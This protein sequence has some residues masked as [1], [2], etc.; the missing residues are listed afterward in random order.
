MAS[1]ARVGFLGVLLVGGLALP[2]S[3]VAQPCGAWSYGNPTPNGNAVATGGGTVVVVAAGG[4]L[5]S[6]DGGPWRWAA[7][8]EF[9]QWTRVAWGSGRFAAIAS[10][11]ILVSEDGLAWRQVTTL[12]DPP[13]SDIES[14]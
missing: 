14:C 8:P 12:R 2:S 13:L 11:A 5:A 9:N 4:V 10:T 3:L 1:N 7:I 6:H